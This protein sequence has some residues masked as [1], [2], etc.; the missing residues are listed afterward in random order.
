[1]IDGNPSPLEMAARVIQPETIAG[2]TPSV[3]YLALA[4]GPHFLQC[5][6][7]APHGACGAQ[8]DWIPR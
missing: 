7:E 6:P 5:D 1:M 4:P 8:S 3:R 2:H